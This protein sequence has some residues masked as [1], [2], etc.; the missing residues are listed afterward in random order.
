MPYIEKKAW[1]TLITLFVVPVVYCFF[2]VNAYHVADP[3][4]HY[5]FQLL[6]IALTVFIAF[7]VILLFI[8]ARLSPDDPKGPLDE[9][10]LQIEL[11]ARRIAYF[12]LM[13]L[14]VATTFVMIHLPANGFSASWGFGNLY[15]FALVGAEIVRFAAQ[16]VYFRKAA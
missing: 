6:T 14:V 10:E 7:Q 13:G 12:V 8:A 9:R 5:L 15:L 1:I 2:M 4:Y 16:I 11:K 3:D